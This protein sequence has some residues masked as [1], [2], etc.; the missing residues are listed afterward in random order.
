[1]VKEEEADAVELVGLAVAQCRSGSAKD[2]L[3]VTVCERG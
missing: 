3:V 1:V 2:P